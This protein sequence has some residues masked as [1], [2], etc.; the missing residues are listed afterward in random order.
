MKDSMQAIVFREYGSEGVLEHAA[1]PRPQVLADSV[2]IRI[3][4]TGVNPADWRLRSGQFR[5]FMRLQMPFIPGSDIAGTVEAVGS[6]VDRFQPGDRVYGMTPVNVGGGYAEFAAVPE[7]MLAPIPQNLSFVEAAAMPLTGLTAL[8]ALRDQAKLGVD[9]HLLIY[10]AS[11]GVGT[12]AIQ[13]AK[14][15]GAHVT[16][17]ASGRNS[18]F[19]RSL[20]ADEVRDYQREDIARGTSRY[21]V[22]FDAVNA[23]PFW[24]WRHV[25]RRG[26]VLAT[27]NPLFNLAI[28]Q[29][30]T[31]LVAGYRVTGFLVQPSGANLESL[32]DWISAGRLRP[33]IERI[34]PLA[35]AA[36]AQRMSATERVRGKLVLAIDPS[37]LHL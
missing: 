2:L 16:A 12:L 18:D 35:E 36:Q 3:A 20:G 31:Q 21:D 28:L 15:I 30:I 29:G 37:L 33:S 8:Q 24:H 27:V 4:A 1:V 26:G 10:G 6:A 11:G 19:V 23:Q 9:D 13:I 22:V 14:A 5:R 32:H 17:V 25:L 34:F 7:R